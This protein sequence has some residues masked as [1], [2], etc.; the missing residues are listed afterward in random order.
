MTGD[1]RMSDLPPIYFD[2]NWRGQFPDFFVRVYFPKQY[3]YILRERAP[4]IVFVQCAGKPLKLYKEILVMWRRFGWKSVL[5]GVSGENTSPPPP[6]PP[7]CMDFSFSY[8]PTDGKNC[9]WI[10]PSAP[11]WS[12]V[13]QRI[14]GA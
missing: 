7:P 4:D 12:A 13:A 1:T 2:S 3:E 10:A 8:N 6:P 14:E 9:A 11:L 5:V